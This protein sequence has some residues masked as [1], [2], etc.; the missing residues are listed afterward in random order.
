MGQDVDWKTTVD[1]AVDTLQHYLR[2]NTTNPPG[3]VTEGAGFLQTILE[4]EGIA[5]TR[6]EA[7]SGKVNL[8]ARLKGS[9]DDKPILL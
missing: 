3:D 7:A 9:G 4:K 1:E 5:V 8:A 2:F 6:Y